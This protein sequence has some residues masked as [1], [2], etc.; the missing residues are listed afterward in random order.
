MLTDEEILPL[1]DKADLARDYYRDGK[2]A[3]CYQEGEDVSEPLL[4]F[5][6]LVIEAHEKKHGGAA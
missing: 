2:Y 6:R 4:D 1:A 3:I 5:A